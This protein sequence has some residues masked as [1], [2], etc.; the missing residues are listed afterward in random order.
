[1]NNGR[2]Y[3]RQIFRITHM[4]FIFVIL[5][6]C[7]LGIFNIVARDA[8]PVGDVFGPAMILSLPVLFLILNARGYRLSYDANAIYMRPQGISWKLR[9]HREVSMRY[10]EIEKMQGEWGGL[11]Y[12]ESGGGLFTPF[13]YIRLYR[14]NGDDKEEFVIDP[15]DLIHEDMQSLVRYILEKRPDLETK[16]ITDYLS[17]VRRI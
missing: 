5:A 17:S 9:Y 11:G 15:F 12:K 2:I 3:L 13:R 6:G 4:M 16:K 8:E 1:M 10:N 7:A 14:I